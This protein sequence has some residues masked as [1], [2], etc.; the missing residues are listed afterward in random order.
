MIEAAS[1]ELS[2]RVGAL[3]ERERLAGSSVTCL[4]TPRRLAIVA[5]SVPSSQPDLTEEVTGPS[6]SIAFKDGQPT[7]AAQAFAKKVG[8]D[9][10][11]LQRKSTPKGEYLSAT[12]TKK[13]R[14]AAESP[15][16]ST[17]ERN[18]NSLLAQ[19]HVLAEA[20]ANSSSARCAGW[21]RCWMGLLFRWNSKE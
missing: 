9:V 2:D 10:A 20:R 8:Q 5:S 3:L 18:C 4:D 1:K 21:L 11:N 17:A 6:V 15:G 13:G 19:E 12:V 14:A 16:G 7:G